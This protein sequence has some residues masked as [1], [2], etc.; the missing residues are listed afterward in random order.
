LIAI[1][2]SFPRLVLGIRYLGLGTRIPNN[3]YPK[4]ETRLVPVLDSSQYPIP[5]PLCP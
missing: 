2:T 1:I 5:N 4:Y 3:Q